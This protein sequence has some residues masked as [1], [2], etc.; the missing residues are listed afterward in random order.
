MSHN[1]PNN[2]LRYCFRSKSQGKFRSPGPKEG[3]EFSETILTKDSITLKC[4]HTHL[5]I[6]CEHV[7]VY[8][9]Y[10]WILKPYNTS[11]DH[12]PSTCTLQQPQPTTL[13]FPDAALWLPACQDSHFLCLATPL[14]WALQSPGAH[15]PSG[16]LPAQGHLLFHTVT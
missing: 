7:S 5:W 16:N 1:T 11:P 10:I 6:S 8:K 13:H 14:L 2:F 12:R 4:V 9:K 3:Q 15:S